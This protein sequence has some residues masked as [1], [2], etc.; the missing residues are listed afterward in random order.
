MRASA[1]LAAL[2][3]LTVFVVLARNCFREMGCAIGLLLSE[4]AASIRGCSSR[5]PV[6]SRVS[7]SG[8]VI[9]DFNEMQSERSNARQ[10]RT[11]ASAPPSDEE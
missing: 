2:V 5:N 11:R 3:I 8:F 1:S 10:E 6:G 4:A 7:T 9:S